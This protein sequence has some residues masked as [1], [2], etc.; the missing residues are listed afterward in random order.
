[1]DVSE[2]ASISNGIAAR[3]AT[4]VFELAKDAK[5]LDELEKDISALGDSIAASEDLR[6]FFA[7]P[8]YTREEMGR[9]AVAFAESAGFG[10]TLKNTLALLA[11]NRRLFVVPALVARI[12]ALI[13]EEK[14]EVTAEVVTAKGLTKAQTEKLAK[15]LN[16]QVGKTVQIEASVD[17]SLIG[18]MIVKVGSR[19]VDTTIKA[20]L[21]ALQNTMKEVG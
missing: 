10:G 9:A 1:V 6:G 21:A 14:G 2:P 19:M 5:A 4:A 16:A 7:S 15:A 8:V 17:E 13:A 20:K 3:Y 11:Q 18:G 12:K